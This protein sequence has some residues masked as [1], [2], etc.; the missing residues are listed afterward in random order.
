[1]RKFVV[2]LATISLVTAITAAPSSALSAS[3]VATA[4]ENETVRISASFPLGTAV[5]TKS[6]KAGIK[7]VVANSGTDATFLVT[8]AAGK[9]PGVS[10]E[11]VQLLAKKRGQVI[12]SYLVKLGVSKASVT[13]KVKINRLGS[14]PKTKIVGS[15]AASAPA[16]AVAAPA[17]ALTCATGG[18]CIVGDRGPGGG[19]VYYVSAAN[20]TSAGST[21]GT[22]C[23]YLEVAPATWQDTTLPIYTTV[24]NDSVYT[25][26]TD[27]A[28][29][30]TQVRNAATPAESGFFGEQEN[31]KIGQG[32]NN[33]QI[34]KVTGATSTAQAAVLA[35]AGNSTAGQWFIP[36]MN[37]L[38][39][40]CKYARGQTTGG[41]TVPCDT[42]GT[43]KTGTASDLGGF[44]DVHYYWS[45]SELSAGYAWIQLFTNG[46]QANNLKVSPHYV[47]P[48][49]AF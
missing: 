46:F 19:I 27:T 25:W 10:D 11:A 49:R 20:F 17:A 36:S 18:T 21:C 24:A 41:L 15:A 40:L 42:S 23:R 48:V 33:T 7:K 37:E 39:E 34:M 30:T 8:A 45:S 1:M 6:Q 29:L 35:Y 14:V 43:L 3:T 5:L 47:R 26:S 22:A 2:L 38:N 9:L 32:F 44:V 28:G 13:T 16:P 4:S 31:W 12:K